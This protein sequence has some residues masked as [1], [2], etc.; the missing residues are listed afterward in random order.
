MKKLF[1]G[2]ALA[3]VLCL[4]LMPTVALAYMCDPDNSTDWTLVWTE[5]FDAGTLPT[6]WT[7]VDKDEDG[8]NWLNASTLIS[9]MYFKT[10]HGTD[11]AMSF[12]FRNTIGKLN[13]DNWLILPEQTLKEGRP[14]QLTFMII[15]QD[16]NCLGDKLGVFISEDGGENYT[17][18]GSDYA[19]AVDWQEI[20]VDLSS[21]AGKTVSIALV[22]HNSYDIYAVALDCVSLW[23]KA[24]DAYSVT[25]DA[26]GGACDT[27]TLSTG[28]GYKLTDLPTPTRD[29]YSFD[30]WFSEAVGGTEITTDTVFEANTTVY[31]HWTQNEQNDQ[32]DQNEQPQAYA[33]IEGADG[34]WLHGSSSALTFRAN[35]DYD[36]FIGVK[37]DDK[38]ISVNDYT[39][40]SGSTVVTLKTDFLKTLSVGKHK[41]TVLYNDGECS[42]YF[43]IR[44]AG[45]EQTEP[46]AP[47]DKT[48]DKN[49]HTG[50]SGA[51][52]LVSAVLSVSALGAAAAA[53]YGRKKRTR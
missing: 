3:L 27:D 30:G 34:V 13:P 16:R 39:A 47:T 10:H 33:I 15:A 1:T 22:H 36:K 41:L 21:Y 51:L 4:A 49:P 8:H 20:T 24:P 32:N 6:G 25:F 19:A 48:P 45:S 12:S 5:G 38:L 2:I 28:E 29:G 18:L 42:T 43:E 44:K 14:Y 31:A 7:A 50:D 40:A 17:Q 35:G 9:P 46:S 37:V 26:N 23:T 52:L 53:V 11:Y